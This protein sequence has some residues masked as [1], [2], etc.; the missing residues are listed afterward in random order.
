[1]RLIVAPHR[2]SSTS[3]LAASTATL[4]AANCLR[5]PGRVRCVYL[6]RPELND[7]QRRRMCRP[8]PSSSVPGYVVDS[9]QGVFAPAKT[10]P[11][12]VQKINA[13]IAKALAEPAVVD[14][15]THTAYSV[16]SSSPDELRKFLKADTEKWESVIK[17]A[18]IRI[19]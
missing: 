3:Y 17:T 4:G 19:D 9:W 18:G 16:V 13:G 6:R 8:S 14:K 15:L 11:E 5:I 7:P 12:I 2:R 1:M 10:P